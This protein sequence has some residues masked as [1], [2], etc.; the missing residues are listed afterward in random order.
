MVFDINV[1][2]KSTQKA[3]KKQKKCFAFLCA[4]FV[5]PPSHPSASHSKI[6]TITS[7]HHTHKMGIMTPPPG[8]LLSD[9]THLPHPL[10]NAFTETQKKFPA[11]HTGGMF[12]FFFASFFF[13]I[14]VF[15]SFQQVNENTAVSDFFVLGFFLIHWV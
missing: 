6:H 11:L 8:R 4:F 5:C 2:T 3:H 10:L 9:P 12:A 1:S 14:L 15:S 7:H 13:G